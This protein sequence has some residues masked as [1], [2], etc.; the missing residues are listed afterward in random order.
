MSTESF[1]AS[2]T[3]LNQFL[4][5]AESSNYVSVPED[6]YVLITDIVRSTEAIESGR[7]KEVNLLGASSIIAVLN[8]VNGLEIPFVFGGDG[9]SILFPP[10]VYQLV[11]DAAL[12][13]R[14]LAR[15][16]FDLELRI[17][18]VSVKQ[19]TIYSQL[20]IAKFKVTPQYSQASFTGGGLTYATNLIKADSR[21]QLEV[22]AET[23]AANLDG[24]ECRWQ[25][26]PSQPGQIVSLIVSASASSGQFSGSVY[27]EVIQKIQ[28]IYGDDKSYNP[29][30]KSA[31]KLSFSLQKLSAEIKA[32]SQ[33]ASLWHRSLYA[34]KVLAENFLGLSFMKFGLVIGNVDWGRYK[35]EVTTA[36]DFQK[37]DDV[38][39][40]VI[41]GTA[42]QTQQLTEYLEQQTQAGYLTYGH[43]VSDR[44]LLTC[45]IFERRDRHIHLVDGADGG[46]ALAA[47]A[48]K[49]RLHRKTINW[50]AYSQLAKRRQLRQ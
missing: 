38:L 2:L 39:Q 9:A 29:V 8:A 21:H 25:D 33:T 7:Y 46:Y 41:A 16:T 4:E 42:A 19:I 20:K 17:G 40:M 11:K 6:W 1:Y 12:S 3:S 18:I 49:Q 32:R 36:S 14:Q 26:I 31:L 5:L 23:P 24:L 10:S 44:A 37:I 35:D 45:L 34:L 47:K 43:H 13:I 48:L 15:N 30:T 50:R 22:T 27:R 28:A